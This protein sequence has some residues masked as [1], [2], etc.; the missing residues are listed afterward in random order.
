MPGADLSHDELSDIDFTNADLRHADLSGAILS[1]AYLSRSNLVWANLET[2]NLSGASLNRA[3]LAGACLKGADLRGADLSYADLSYTDLT[4]A[5]LSGAELREADLSWAD[6]SGA[7]LSDAHLTGSLLDV[8]NLT[9][10]DLRR[11]SL[12][13]T[14]LE[15]TMFGEGILEMTLFGDCDLSQVLGLETMRH[16]GPSIIG[17]DTLARSRGLIPLEFLRQAGVAEPFIALQEQFHYGPESGALDSPQT[18][19]FLRTLLVGSVNDDD[20]IRGL[21]ADLKAAGHLCWRLAVDDEAVFA[22]DENES[23][24]NRFIYYDQLA[25]ICSDSSLG[26]PYGWRSFEQIMRE[27]GGDGGSS[28]RLALPVAVTLDDR[29]FQSRESL[30]ADIIKGPLIDLRNYGE[31]DRYQSGLADLIASLSR[32]RKPNTGGQGP[33]TAEDSERKSTPEPIPAPED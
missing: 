17:L 22:E 3:H 29:I 19:P 1:S 28:G 5:N 6:L 27:R 33:V 7:C 9:G 4:G 20:F 10:A 11:A 26:S 8:A 23:L 31:P 12:V 24:L 21:E 18:F 2:A 30:C 15:R 13:R 25:L 32:Q 14:R 16:V